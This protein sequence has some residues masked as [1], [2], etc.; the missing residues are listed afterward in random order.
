MESGDRAKP[1]LALAR[2]AP[3][4]GREGERERGRARERASEREGEQE[5]GQARES[6]SERGVA[7]VAEH[8][9]QVS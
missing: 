5:R 9:I 3:E 1:S 4:R 6:A 7:L 2:S 8:R